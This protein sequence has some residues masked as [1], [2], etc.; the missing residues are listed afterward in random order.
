MVSK[1]LKRVGIGTLTFFSNLNSIQAQERPDTLEYNLEEIIVEGRRSTGIELPPLFLHSPIAEMINM[2]SNTTMPGFSEDKF[3]WIAGSDFQFTKGVPRV[4]IPT[5][6]QVSSMIP[7][8][9]TREVRTRSTARTVSLDP[10]TEIVA[11]IEEG[12]NF[13]INPFNVGVGYGRQGQ[14][15]SFGLGAERRI[16]PEPLTNWKK[17]FEIYGVGSIFNFVGET[18]LSSLDFSVQGS[19]GEQDIN[20]NELFGTDN[21]QN[22]LKQH[23]VLAQ[24]ANNGITATVSSQSGVTKTKIDEID[25]VSFRSNDVSLHTADLEFGS[26]NSA[27]GIGGYLLDRSTT[28]LYGEDTSTDFSGLKLFGEKF[29]YLSNGI[30]LHGNSKVDVVNDEANFSSYISLAMQTNLVDVQVSGASLSDYLFGHRLTDNILLFRPETGV[31]SQN[32]NYLQLDLEKRLEDHSFRGSVQA[33][34]GNL[35]RISKTA[36]ISGFIWE[37][38]YSWHDKDRDIATT[39]RGV[40]RD[41]E[42]FDGGLNSPLPISPEVEFNGTFLINKGKFS[43]VVNGVWQYGLHFPDYLDSVTPIGNRYLLNGAIGKTFGDHGAL[44]IGLTNI[45]KPFIKSPL[46]AYDGEIEDYP[47]GLEA[48]ARI[49]FQ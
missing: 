15:F 4:I 7:R 12:M 1:W 30:I 37:L 47:L 25:V 41:I 3:Y 16:L 2:E 38:L 35:V 23:F 31:E 44:V 9:H 48:S 26:N 34:R 19:Y 29:L 39:F 45:L 22:D 40:Y 32:F 24:V 6:Y 28:G 49:S 5:S 42:M 27:V 21:F 36:E 33:L 8:F 10:P 17:E 20:S 43:F 13:L 46:L 14:H 11:E 18:R